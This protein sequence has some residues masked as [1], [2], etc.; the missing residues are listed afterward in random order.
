MANKDSV[1]EKAAQ[2]EKQLENKDTITLGLLRE[3]TVNK[4]RRLFGDSGYGTSLG[5]GAQAAGR[6]TSNAA[7]ERGE[8]LREM[9]PEVRQDMREAAAEERR[10]AKEPRGMKKG[11]KVSSASSRAD[12]IAKRGKTRGRMV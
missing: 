8:S 5:A 6:A 4:V 3:G 10:E 2:R 9:E 1:R 11:G 7:W 12:G